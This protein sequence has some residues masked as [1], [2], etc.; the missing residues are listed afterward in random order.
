MDNSIKLDLLMPKSFANEEIFFIWEVDRKRV[1]P[2]LGIV[3]LFQGRPIL[4]PILIYVTGNSQ[5]I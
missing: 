4:V 2:I 1:T 5:F 3:N